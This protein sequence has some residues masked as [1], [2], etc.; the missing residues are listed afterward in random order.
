MRGRQVGTSGAAL[1]LSNLLTAHGDSRLYSGDVARFSVAGLK[2]HLL[3]MLDAHDI[4]E[5]SERRVDAAASV[6][7]DEVLGSV[8]PLSNV[9][10]N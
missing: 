2:A 7:I 10:A 1:C 6:F 4:A 8:K 5:L 3:D 9:Q